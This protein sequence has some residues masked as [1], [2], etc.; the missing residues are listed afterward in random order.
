MSITTWI[1]ACFQKLRSLLKEKENVMTDQTVIEPNATPAAEN[2]AQPSTS[3]LDDFANETAA[4]AA[5]AAQPATVA[6][7]PA[8][9][10]AS[11]VQQDITAGVKDFALA[12][13][14]VEQG[15]V[16]LGDAA[17]NELIALARK[18]L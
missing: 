6:P 16:K 4:A 5:P 1:A 2:V 9:A 17:K 18:Y 10:A 11:A 12:F 15:V 8:S 14:F 13:S 3:P 7:A